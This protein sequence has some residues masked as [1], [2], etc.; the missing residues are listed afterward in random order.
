ML[1]YPEDLSV[2]YSVLQKELCDLTKCVTF[3][4][5]VLSWL[6]QAG[7]IH[8]IAITRARGRQANVSEKWF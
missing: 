1:A 7:W 8:P 5:E 2:G 6:N 4:V 3:I